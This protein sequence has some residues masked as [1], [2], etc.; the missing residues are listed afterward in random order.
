V[1]FWR[2]NQD[3]WVGDR[4]G[5]RG[6]RVLPPTAPGSGQGTPAGGPAA[7]PNPSCVAIS[8]VGKHLADTV[9][10]RAVDRLLGW[11]PSGGTNLRL[12]RASQELQR[13]LENLKGFGCGRCSRRP[14]GSGGA[15]DELQGLKVARVDLL[16]RTIRL[17]PRTTK[18]G[19][20]RTAPVDDA[21]AVWLTQ[22]VLGKNANRYVSTF[23][24][25]V[26]A[27]VLMIAGT[28]L[29]GS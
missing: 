24:R 20:G 21:L 17:E 28:S 18:N 3:A 8:A 5:C 29:I 13:V 7:D 6:S 4:D 15:S 1:T 10:E 12:E 11:M 25:R 16:N 14:T 22:V 26:A 19:R 27:P 2:E 9:L 23:T